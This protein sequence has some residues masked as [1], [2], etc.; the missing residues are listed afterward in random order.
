MNLKEALAVMQAL[1]QEARDFAPSPASEAVRDIQAFP[2]KFS[3]WYR[4]S[5]TRLAGRC[6]PCCNARHLVSPIRLRRRLTS[7]YG[8]ST[9]TAS[10]HRGFEPAESTKTKAKSDALFFTTGREPGSFCARPSIDPHRRGARRALRSLGRVQKELPGSRSIYAHRPS[11]LHDN[12]VAPFRRV[13][14]E[15]ISAMSQ[16]SARKLARRLGRP[17]STRTIRPTQMSKQP[18]YLVFTID[19]DG[20]ERASRCGQEAPHHPSR[21]EA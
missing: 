6:F 4:D 18:L 13:D 1:A 3:E 19:D 8:Q 5:V 11:S 9:I 7:Y 14:A 17:T 20:T 12:S 16:E 15:R 10:I 2:A 21:A